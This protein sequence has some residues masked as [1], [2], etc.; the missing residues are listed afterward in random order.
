[1][2]M[3]LK[4]CEPTDSWSS[5]NQRA[6]VPN[7]TSES[8]PVIPGLMSIGP[9]SL[10]LLSLKQINKN[11]DLVVILIILKV[12]SFVCQPNSWQFHIIGWKGL[13]AQKIKTLTHFT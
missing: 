8:K 6:N 10:F 4:E 7:I 3:L 2:Y 12:T 5:G 11:Y 1:M 13:K 9:C